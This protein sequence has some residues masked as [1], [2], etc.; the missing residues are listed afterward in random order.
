MEHD[1]KAAKWWF[2][3]QFNNKEYDDAGY[4][5]S[6]YIKA[7]HHALLLAEKVTGE[8]SVGMLDVIRNARTTPGLFDAVVTQA[9]E[10]LKQGEG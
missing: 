8:P 10:E 2:D 9:I 7:T 6:D 3:E 1:Y 4:E 5:D